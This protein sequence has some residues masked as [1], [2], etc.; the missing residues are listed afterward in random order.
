MASRRAFLTAG[1]GGALALAVGG[2]IYRATQTSMAVPLQQRFAVDGEARAALAAIVPALLAGA[3]SAGS[4]GLPS[5]ATLIERVHHSILILPPASR[6][7]VQDLFGLLAL[8]PARRV[9]TGISGGWANATPHDVHVF[10]QSWRDSNFA[11]LRA[12]YGALHDMVLGAWYADPA[13]WAAIGYPGPTLEWA[14]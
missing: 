8:A 4:S 3:L 6:R 10:L 2:G 7:Q 14:A 5:V 1:V 12:A 13:T 9:L 11:M